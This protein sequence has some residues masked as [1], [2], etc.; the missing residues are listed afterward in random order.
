MTPFFPRT[1]QLPVDSSHKPTCQK[2]AQTTVHPARKKIRAIES[3]VPILT[4]VRGSSTDTRHSGASPFGLLGDDLDAARRSPIS[5]ATELVAPNRP[6]A[7]RP[8]PTQG[9]HPASQS[10]L[11]SA[12]F[13][14]R[15]GV[16]GN[17]RR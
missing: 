17:I 2:R 1:G 4:A 7:N 12:V 11:A 16:V 3:K 14:Q 8:L 6:P 5:A 10:S 15:G 13:P 9:D